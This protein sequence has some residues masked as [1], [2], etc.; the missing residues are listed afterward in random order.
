MTDAPETAYSEH[1]P[2]DLIS[3]ELQA[4][5]ARGAAVAA[6]AAR[7]RVWIAARLAGSS[8]RPAPLPGG[9]TA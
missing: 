1:A 9:K 6:T 7:L 8:A 3:L 4:R 2:L 5:A